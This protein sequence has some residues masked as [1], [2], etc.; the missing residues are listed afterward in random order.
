MSAASLAFILYSLV[1]CNEPD[2]SVKPPTDSIPFAS[3]RQLFFDDFFFASQKD[4]T[5]TRHIPRLEE[6]VFAREQPWKHKQ[7]SYTSVSRENNRLQMLTIPPM[8]VPK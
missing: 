8:F 7:S 1:Q 3:H 5:L 4:V 2:T 6:V